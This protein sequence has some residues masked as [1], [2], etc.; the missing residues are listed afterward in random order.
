MS[1]E[2]HPLAP[3]HL[4]A[5][6]PGPD[7]SDPLFTAMIVFLVALLLFIGN[8]YFKLHAIPEHLAH[9]HNN[10]QI[11]FITILAILALFTHN[12][13]F[14]VAALL[15]AVVKLPDFTTPINAIAKSLEQLAAS[16]DKSKE[17]LPPQE[18]D[19]P[20]IEASVENTPDTVNEED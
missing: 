4:P 9:K 1:V 17:S 19:A 6:L 3:H 18:V 15:L 14:W 20:E 16:P 11:Q 2:A 13:I 8:L 5:Y 10:T 7:G 12:N